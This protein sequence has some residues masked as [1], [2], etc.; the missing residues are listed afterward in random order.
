ME[1][2]KH[3][4]EKLNETIAKNHRILNLY[5]RW[6]KWK[7]D[8]YGVFSFIQNNDFK[9][10]AVYGMGS[11]GRSLCSELES[12]N[13]KVMYVIDQNSYSEKSDYI[14]YSIQD[15]LPEADVII[16]T[17]IMSH[18]EIAEKLVEKVRCPLLSLDDIVP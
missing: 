7:N 9:N 15:E 3:T 17:P 14:Y 13:I 11:L 18:E 2:D 16:I 1:H 6:M 4:I 5:E 8:G 12:Q 10:V